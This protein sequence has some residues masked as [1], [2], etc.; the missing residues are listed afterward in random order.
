MRFIQMMDIVNNRGSEVNHRHKWLYNYTSP[1]PVGSIG[2]TNLQ[3]KLKHS[4]PD[5]PIRYYA[6]TSH[7]REQRLGSNVTDGQYVNYDTG[8]GPGRLIDKTFA[9]TRDFKIRHGFRF[10][11]LRELDLSTVPI[12]GSL[13]QYSWNNRIATTY[14]SMHTGEKFLPLPGKYQ[15]PDN[16]VPR[17][18]SYPRVTSVIGLPNDVQESVTRMN[19]AGGMDK[20]GNQIGDNREV[21]DRIPNPRNPFLRGKTYS[22]TNTPSTR[23]GHIRK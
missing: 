1:G 17:G 2:D 14:K 23:M 4:S 13:P 8:S 10:Q 12:Q 22:K 3:V 18:G 9:G 20:A 15:L 11:D 16:E 6:E 7:K 19:Y 21:K 5:M